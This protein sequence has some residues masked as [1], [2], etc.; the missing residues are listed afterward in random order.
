MTTVL[1]DSHVAYWWTAEPDS[2]SSTAGELLAQADELAVA[3]ITWWELSWLA[4]RERILLDAPIRTWL[5][6]L[7]GRF[8]T[9]PL[10]HSIAATAS[11]L[12]RSF[13]GDPADRLIY[14]TA[15]EEGLSLVTKDRRLLQHPFPRRIAFW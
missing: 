9:V 12:P 13:P 4:S 14:A 10:T 6:D 3:S 15:I 2:V 1:L 7:S 8:Q 11:E 5:A